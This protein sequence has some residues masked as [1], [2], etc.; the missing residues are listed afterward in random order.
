M[1]KK[2]EI[3]MF[4]MDRKEVKEIKSRER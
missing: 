4:I 2:G 3:M 1:E